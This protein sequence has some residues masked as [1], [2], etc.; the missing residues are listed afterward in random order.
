MAYGWTDAEDTFRTSKAPL[1]EE[2]P[3]LV[4]LHLRGALSL[5]RCESIV[6]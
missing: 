5:D 1:S 4:M 3:D 6:L 2:L